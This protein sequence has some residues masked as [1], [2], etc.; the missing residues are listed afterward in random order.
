MVSSVKLTLR[1]IRSISLNLVETEA[2]KGRVKSTS[3][4]P[5]NSC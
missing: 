1:S 4:I 3:H 5:V 2:H